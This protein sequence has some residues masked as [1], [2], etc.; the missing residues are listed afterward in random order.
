MKKFIAQMTIGL[1]ALISIILTLIA[2]VATFWVHAPVL[3]H[4]G[5]GY[6][7]GYII[8][9]ITF[10][11]FAYAIGPIYGIFVMDDF[12]PLIVSYLGIVVPMAFI[13]ISFFL[14]GLIWHWLEGENQPS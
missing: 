9:F 1:L 7:W 6:F 12:T 5:L 10:P 4:M 8:M 13:Y 11:L 2:L 14:G 3:N